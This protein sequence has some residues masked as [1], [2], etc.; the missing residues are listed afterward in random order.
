MWAIAATFYAV[1]VFHRMAL[2][3]AGLQ[4]ESRM[5][6]S[7]G[8]LASFTFLQFGVYLAMQ[9]PAG[10]AADRIG[11]RRVL[12][13]GLGLLAAGELVFALATSLPVGL[14]ARVL[15]GMGDALVFLNVLAVA[16]R[17]FPRRLGSLLAALT[18]VVGALGQLVGTVPL[19][20]ALTHLG[21]TTTFAIAAAAT[22]A[23]IVLAL[24]AIRDHPP[25]VAGGRAVAGGRGHAIERGAALERGEAIVGGDAIERGA[26]LDRGEAI[27]PEHPMRALGAAFRHPATRHGFWVHLAMFGPFHVVAG[28]WGV[29]FLVESQGFTRGG[30]AYFPL[31]LTVAFAISGPVLGALGGR[32]SRHQDAIVG[33]AGVLVVATWS[34]I[35]IWP[36]DVIPHALLVLGFVVLGIAAATGMLAFDIARRRNPSAPGSVSAVVNCGGYLAGAGTALLTGQLLHAGLSYRVALAPMLALTAMG[37][38]RCAQAARRDSNLETDC[39]PSGSQ[40][41]GPQ[42]VSG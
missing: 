25:G 19:Q 3:V 34:A 21:W 12:A 22:A 8:A 31:A 30:A 4:A 7:H 28:L 27:E 14:A 16:Q 9:V 6:V 35:L 33:W 26:A 37:L 18:G 11:P 15:I 10:I 5:D 39:G 17:W 40:P 2:G 32:S 29:P 36:A 42:S 38:V 1:A 20:Q 41:Y 23:L 24:A 13:A